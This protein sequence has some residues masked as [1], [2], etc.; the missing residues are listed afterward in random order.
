MRKIITLFITSVLSFSM[1]FGIGRIE[2]THANSNSMRAAW[3][4]TV[5]NIDWPSDSSKGNVGLQ[6]QEFV[7]LIDKLKSVGI[8]T[9]MIQVR[10]ESDTIYKSRINPWSRYLTGVQGRNPGYDPLEFIVEQCHKRGIKVHAWFNPYRACIY[11]DKSS[12]SQNNPINTHPEWVKN[13]K[14]KWYYDPGIPEVT[15]YIVDTV[16]EVV[17]N[18]DVDGVHFDDYFY[19]A[20][21]F[22]DQDTYD[23]YGKGNRDNWRRNNINSM[24]KS[25]RD[26]VHSINPRVE[27]GISP[28]GIWRNKSNDPNGSNTSGGES[29]VKQYADTRYWIKNGLVDYVVPQVYWRIG[30]PKADYKTLI[31]WWSD[32][33]K[34]TKVKL[35]IGEGIY[36]HGQKEYAGEDVAAEIRQQ[37]LLNRQY[38]GISGE[39]F[40]SA[41]DIVNYPQ[42]YNDIKSVYLANSTNTDKDTGDKYR[43]P[44]QSSLIGK[45]RV[46]TAIEIS[47]KAYPGGSDSVVLVNGEDMISGIISSPFAANNSAP[48]LLSYKN[49]VSDQTISEI[50]RLGAK[51]MYIIGRNG[52][53][54]E[55]DIQ[56]ISNEL[57]NISIEKIYSDNN[58]KQS[59]SICQ[60]LM[61]DKKPDNLYI[62]SEDALADVLSISSLA[63]K[64]KNPIIIVEK[65]RVDEDVLKWIKSNKLNSIYFIGGPKS[66]DESVISKIRSVSN[67]SIERI[68]GSNRINTNLEVISKFYP[69]EFYKKAFVADS[70]AMIDAITVSTF[71]Q[72]T[73]S[74]IIL[75][76]KNVSKNQKNI[77]E[78]KSS[79]LVY[80]VGGV[81]SN[82]SYIEILKLLSGKMPV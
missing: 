36:K 1:L 55:N 4:S 75:V 70:S 51:K 47:K 5:F 69:Q 59:I 11:K 76:G 39:V 19:P 9:I 74:P 18:Y 23:K 78:P 67:S 60:R 20:A 40:F 38:D 62:A 37:L 73:N 53:I 54:G 15:K 41:K 57:P 34:G 12:T 72:K 27:F 48:I 30:H 80:K 68:Y 33:V 17:Q 16:S 46:E 49:R 42:V 22:P 8:N 64:E 6:K 61:L 71:A 3:V 43:D 29:Y 24:V 58:Q 82:T 21:D 77:L 26:A 25:V 31:K 10:P 56:K 65:N 79:S 52:F 13:Y 45:T 2:E 35:Y 32:Q 44:Y 66:I 7:S 50:K 14:N 63:A 81:V 28:A